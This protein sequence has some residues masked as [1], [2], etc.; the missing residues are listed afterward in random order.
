LYP[1]EIPLDTVFMQ[2]EKDAAI[3]LWQFILDALGSNSS[4][5]SGLAA[6]PG[7]GLQVNIAAG[8]LYQFGEIDPTTWSDM[9]SDESS[10][11]LQGINFATQALTGFTPPGTAGQSIDYLIECQIQVTDEA[12]VSTPFTDGATPPST[13]YQMQSPA[14]Q[15]VIA[16]QVKAGSA[17]TTGSQ[18]PPSPDAGWVPLWVVAVDNGESGFSSGDISLAPNAPEFF[19]FVHTNPNG[20]TPVFLSPLSQQTGFLNISGAALVGGLVAGYALIGSGATLVTNFASAFKGGF[21]GDFL[22]LS[23]T[24]GW[25]G[26]AQ[27]TDSLDI[28]GSIGYTGA[29]AGTD[30]DPYPES[31]LNVAMLGGKLASDYALASGHYLILYTGTPTAD[32]TNINAAIAGYLKINVVTGTAP[33]QVTSTTLCTNLNAQFVGG[34][35]PGNT[36]GEIAVSNGTLCVNLNAQYLNGLPSSAFQLAGSYAVMNATN[37]GTFTATGSIA[38]T[39]G[40]GSSQ[41]I[42]NYSATNGFGLNSGGALAYLQ[43]QSAPL[44]LIGSSILT[45]GPIFAGGDSPQNVSAKDFIPTGLMRAGMCVYTVTSGG[46]GNTYPYPGNGVAIGTKAGIAGEINVCADSVLSSEFYIGYRCKI[47]LSGSLTVNFAGLGLPSGTIY[48]D[49]SV[50]ATVGGGP[51]VPNPQPYTFSAGTHTVDIV[52][53]AYN[54]ALAYYTGSEGASNDWGGNLT[55]FGWLPL[56]GGKISSVIT[57]ITPG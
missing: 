13:V 39:G 38:T 9:P 3:A 32:P 28:A 49:G 51:G 53:A 54:M 33:L 14:R 48:V 2:A 42:L 16:F 47:T 12:T 56:S 6:T 10:W 29:H 40:T 30:L 1:S 41:A 18:T 37:S 45:S 7:T 19:G 20:N 4:V 44:G 23:I 46:T 27:S 11:M 55:V 36:S 31:Q 57:A 22:S 52:Y 50:V 26:A 21:A 24:G 35:A 17:A 15:N 25:P 8:S 43:S 34:L 5:F